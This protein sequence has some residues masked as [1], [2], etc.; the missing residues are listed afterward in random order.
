MR[1]LVSEIASRSGDAAVSVAGDFNLHVDREEDLA[2]F[3]LL[4]DGA[5]LTDACAALSCGSTTIDHVLFRSGGGV[6]LEASN[7]RQP[8]EFVDAE[9]GED[10]SDHIPTAVRISWRR[11]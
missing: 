4:R 8:P 1:R 3:D 7:W 2:T 9:T 11:L 6:T 10:L 5:F